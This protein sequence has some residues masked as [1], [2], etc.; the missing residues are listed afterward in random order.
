M[1]PNLFHVDW[2]QLTETLAAVVVLAFIVER[3]LALVVEHRAFVSRFN[4]K[5]LKEFLAL[6]LALCVCWQWDF[7]AVSVV[8]TNDKNT[9]VGQLLTAAVIAGGSKAALKLFRDVL[10]IKSTAVKEDE[11]KQRA[12]RT[13]SPAE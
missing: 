13:L 2:E 7:D 9:F 10:Q 11:E 8:R 6:A 5:G 1:D 12:L 3:A 4:R